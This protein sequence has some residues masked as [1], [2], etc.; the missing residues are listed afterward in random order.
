[1]DWNIAEL[2]QTREL[3]RQVEA[4]IGE[5]NCK[6]TTGVVYLRQEDAAP[7]ADGLG[8]DWPHLLLMRQL[9][10]Q[11]QFDEARIFRWRFDHKLVQAHLLNHYCAGAVP[12]SRGVWRELTGRTA[13]QGVEH[14]RFLDTQACIIK[15]SLSEASGEKDEL[16]QLEA[17][18]K[19]VFMKY[20]LPAPKKLWEEEYHI[21][22]RLRIR[23]EY[24]VHSLQGE[25]VPDLTF[26]RFSSRSPTARETE[27]ANKFVQHVLDSLPAALVAGTLYGWDVA[28]TAEGK[29]AV[30]EANPS[31]FHPVFRRG[32]QCSGVFQSVFGGPQAIALLLRF[33]ANRYDVEIQI[34][35]RNTFDDKSKLYWLV[36]ESV[37][38]SET[39]SRFYREL[40]DG[41][42][43][44]TPTLIRSFDPKLSAAENILL[45]AH[46]EVDQLSEFLTRRRLLADVGAPCGS[47]KVRIGLA[48][49][50][51]YCDITYEADV[52]DLFEKQAETRPNAIAVESE[53]GSITYQ[54]LDIRSNLLARYLQ[55]S[56]IGP[57][58][59]VAVCVHRGPLMVI[60]LLGALKAGAAYLPLDPSYPAKRLEYMLRNA[61]PTLILTE[62]KVRDRL[63]QTHTRQSCVDSDL[64]SISSH[65]AVRVLR[66]IKPRNLAYVIYTSGSTGKPKAV[67]V[68]HCALTNVLVYIQRLLNVLPGDRWL[69]LTT[70]SFDIAALE[71]FVPLISGAQL[72]VGSEEMAFDGT[73]LCLFLREA[74]PSIMQATPVT[75]QIL[76][77]A[78]WL[79]SP[80]LRA[81]C[82]GDVL[83]TALASLLK[84]NCLQLWNLYGPTETTIWSSVLEV[85]NQRNR[86]TV[87]RPISNTEIYVLGERL[88]CVPPETVGEIYIGGVGVARGY[89][90]DRGLT[91]ERFI[92]SMHGGPGTRLYRTGDLG[93]W[94]KDGTLEFLGRSDRQVKVLG[95]RVALGEIEDLLKEHSDVADA[96]IVA[97]EN[98][99]AH[100]TLVAYVVPRQGSNL[101]PAQVLEFLKKRLPEYMVPKI[102]KL[103]ELPLTPTGKI[104]RTSLMRSGQN[105]SGNQTFSKQADGDTECALV[106][107]WSKVFG[108]TDI[109]PETNFLDLGGD[110]LYAARCLARVRSVFGTDLPF[111]TLF[112]DTAT[113]KNIAKLIDDLRSRGTL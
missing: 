60:A 13:S 48:G 43:D 99:P 21:Q 73:K 81:L 56:G 58:S 44:L 39:L 29:W 59:V 69:A 22:Q 28:V 55:L 104:D 113:I 64:F 20:P 101:A 102:V 76:L 2:S 61:R 49:K 80:D 74:R 94:C 98:A 47:S 108:V 53:G 95:N 85:T 63:P 52:V 75:W 18:C 86:I 41:R 46:A 27:E 51:N 45:S 12:V 26:Y 40:C 82:G 93:R 7:L 14:L 89:M 36:A 9:F 30:I 5:R 66:K 78:G 90:N 84:K 10:H 37:R 71:V 42:S 23:Q 68:E 91:A 112:E 110:S 83:H 15:A 109:G 96:A 105:F 87:G 34:E 31:G 79:G 65:C 11:L 35:P 106:E 88:E 19:A 111:A 103:T 38:F 25:V 100:N 77:E 17:A 62:T 33:I 72:I 24:R 97:V 32:F 4:Y 70:I 54:E 1:M 8:V 57:E 92:A 67:A 3:A 50:S 107:I 16:N 6:V